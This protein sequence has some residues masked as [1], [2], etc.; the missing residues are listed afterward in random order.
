[1]VLFFYRDD[2][3]HQFLNVKPTL[4]S[5][6]KFHLVMVYNP[7]CYQIRFA[8]ILLRN[9]LF[10]RDIGLWFLVLLSLDLVAG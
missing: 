6:A 5:W 4:R 10:K 7:L 8:N 1:M 2:V 9:S 3:L